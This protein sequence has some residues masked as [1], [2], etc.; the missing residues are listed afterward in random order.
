M[1]RKRL[2]RGLQHAGGAV[3]W[4]VWPYSS[5]M[6]AGRFLL[7]N[8]LY[9]WLDL[10]R[11]IKRQPPYVPPPTWEISVFTAVQ[12]EDG[13]LLWRTDMEEDLWLLPGGRNP[14]MTP[15]W[16]TAVSLTQQ[17]T[18]QKIHLLDLSGVYVA[19]NRCRMALLFTAVVEGE[20]R[21]GETAASAV[22][23]A[24]VIAWLA[25]PPENAPS[26]H[27]Q[28]VEDAALPDNQTNFRLL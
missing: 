1:S 27:K 28:Y 26:Q 23:N 4:W 17:Q 10:K 6:H 19:E 2:E 25:A 11:K 7:F 15:P 13:D 8:V 12:N 20:Q 5:W 3:E 22:L 18:G 14:K 9:R 16:E 21:E 24:G